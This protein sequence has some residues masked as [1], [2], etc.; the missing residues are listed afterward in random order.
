M[1]RFDIVHSVNPMRQPNRNDC[2]ATSI[3]MVYRTTIRRVK[4]IAS[5]NQIEINNDGSLPLNNHQNIVKLCRCFQMRAYRTSRVPAIARVAELMSNHPV[6][7]LGRI[8]YTGGPQMHALAITSLVG[9]GR[10]DNTT[11]GLVDPTDGRFHLFHYED[12][13]SRQQGPIGQTDYI[14]S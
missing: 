6:V 9:E 8:N 10:A 14:I 7:L 2:W 13:S 12:F 5:L 3:A 11:I 4:G 1:P